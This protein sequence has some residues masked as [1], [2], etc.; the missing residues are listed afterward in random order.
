MIYGYK[1]RACGQTYETT[2]RVDKLITPCLVCRGEITRDYSGIALQRPVMPHF[3]ATVRQEVI[4]MNDFREKLKVAGEK[5][6]ERTGIETRY[7][8]IEHGDVPVT[9]E[10]L[11]ATNEQRAKNGMK[12][13][14]VP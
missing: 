3:N 12:P 11:D 4:G 5:Y 10:G 9:S 8:P 1:C 14:R 7:V 6:T 13:I 2:R